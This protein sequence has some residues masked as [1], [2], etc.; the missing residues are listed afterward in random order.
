MIFV[1]VGTN[2]APF[3]RLLRAV[4]R[5]P[6]DEVVVAQCGSSSH[7]P[8][9]ASCV[10]FLP[11]DALVEHVRAADTVVTHA[12]AGSVIVALLNGKRPVVVPRLRRFGEAVDDHQL[13]FAEHLA[14][15]GLVTVV[16]DP[17]RLADAIRLGS[18]RATPDFRIG[19][20][21]VDELRGY[22]AELVGGAR[23]RG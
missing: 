7:R 9:R 2:E 15:R 17:D 18:S 12:G 10:D 22:L 4:D 3:D 5:L 6:E 11:F 14:E 1:S 20:A 16:Q 23:G 21:L 13:Q 19:G 8:S